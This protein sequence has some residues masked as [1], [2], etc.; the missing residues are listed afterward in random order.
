MKKAIYVIFASLLAACLFSC[1]QQDDIYKEF[2]VPGGLKYPQKVDT[3]IVRSGYN[4][5]EVLWPK[6]VDPSVVKARLFYNS[7][8]DSLEVDMISVVDTARVILDNIPE[9]LYTF[10]LYTYDAQGNRSMAMEQSGQPYGEKY[11]SG[12]SP[13]EITYATMLTTECAYFDF[14][15]A[16]ADLLYC[17]FQYTSTSGEEKT[18]NLDPE[19]TSIMVEDFKNGSPYRIRCIYKPNKG[20]DTVAGE[21]TESSDPLEIEVIS[22]PKGTWKNMALPTDTWLSYA[23]LPQYVFE[24]LWNGQLTGD[25]YSCWASN[26]G[27]KVIW[28]SI[29]LGYTVSIQSLQLHHRLPW[30]RYTGAGVRRFQLWGSNDPAPDGSWDSWNLLGEFETKKPSGY[31]PD[32]SVGTITAEDQDYFDNHNVYTLEKT[33]LVTDPFQTVRYVR[34]KLLDA[35]STYG[36]NNPVNYVIGEI[37]IFGTFASIKERNKYVK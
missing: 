29:D 11:L 20:V 19:A 10:S 14:S 36:N 32:G 30:E 27:D 3:L 1:M 12:R 2:V 16:V 5:L 26:V 23:S 24:N 34:F 6:T 31:E 18:I 4:K 13:K 8:L 25:G 17:E 7:G 37:T 21:W 35:F 22:L 28:F 33:D 9:G 15:P